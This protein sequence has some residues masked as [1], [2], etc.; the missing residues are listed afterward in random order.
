MTY[1]E[2][3][4]ITDSEPL[5]SGLCYTRTAA[6]AEIQNVTVNPNCQ[7]LLNPSF[8]NMTALKKLSNVPTNDSNVEIV[9]SDVANLTSNSS[10]L[11]VEDVV[12]TSMVLENVASISS[13][14]EQ[15]TSSVLQ[16]LSNILEAPEEILMNAHTLGSSTTRILESFETISKRCP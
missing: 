5:L 7:F 13:I 16:T 12:F 4:C 15:T 2:E 3:L 14:S 11:T 10:D 9:A 8:A 1:S 6:P